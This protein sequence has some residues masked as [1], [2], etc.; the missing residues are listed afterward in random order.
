MEAVY[1]NRECGIAY[2]ILA[3]HTI[4]YSANKEITLEQLVK[5]I[6]VMFDVYTKEDK[7]LERME[8]I[9]EKEGKSIITVN[10]NTK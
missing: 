10:M 6:R 3:L 7:L 1:I 9:L 8:E 4:S 5:E 2:F